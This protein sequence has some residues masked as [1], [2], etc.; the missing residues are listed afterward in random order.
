[1]QDGPVIAGFRAEAVHVRAATEKDAIAEVQAGQLD[2]EF[3]FAEEL[4]AARLLHGAVAGETVI[5]HVAGRE[6]FEPGERMRLTVDPAD[7]QLFDAATGKRLAERI[8]GRAQR[9][10][11]RR[12]FASA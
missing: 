1:V 7:V 10:A 2:G 9:A 5:A 12:A 3:D 11:Q 8:D 4:G 6:H